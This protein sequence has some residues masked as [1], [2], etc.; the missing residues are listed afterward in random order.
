MTDGGPAKFPLPMKFEIPWMKQASRK[1]R[2]L[3]GVSGGADSVALLHLLAEEGF[4]N[5]IVCHLNHGLRG[6]HSSGDASFTGRLA[7]ELGFKSEMGRVDLRQR[8]QRDGESM[9]TAARKAR[10]EFFAESARKHRC[11]KVLLAHHADDQAETVLWNL[12][13]G[14]HGLK[15]MLETHELT[16]AGRK[17]MLIRPLL[18][19]RHFD[20]V[21]W[22]RE[23][24][25]TWREDASNAEP[26]AVRNRLRM[27]AFPLLADISGRDPV[28][29][30]V[31][32]VLDAREHQE[33]EREWLAGLNLLDPQQRLHLPALRK[34]PAALRRVAIRDFL[35]KNGIPSI[36][37]AL[38][39]RALELTNADGVPSVNL[40][41][42]L[43]L[44]RSGGRI[45]IGS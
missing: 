32:A 19:L 1:A 43:R 30:F 25:L 18:A 11:N 7:A 9:E 22:L 27:E 6:R 13:R 14:S 3:V 17:L 12:L 15:G 23:R 35:I 38:L 29:A 24:G 10:H 16:V 4:R 28:M 8:M 39:D 41:G 33:M 37:R 20:L 5:V 42:G 26:V 2:L 21:A 36:D 44:R 45:W 34:L 40:P 31:R